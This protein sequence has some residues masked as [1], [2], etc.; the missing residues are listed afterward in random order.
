M[1][2]TEHFEEL[3]GAVRHFV[4]EFMRSVSH[5]IVKAGVKLYDLAGRVDELPK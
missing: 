4:G 1:T 3:R 5:G 2:T